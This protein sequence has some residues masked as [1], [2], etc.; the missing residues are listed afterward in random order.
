MLKAFLPICPVPGSKTALEPEQKFN[1]RS[2]QIFTP[3]EE[4]GGVHCSHPHYRRDEA[5]VRLRIQRGAID[6]DGSADGENA[7]ACR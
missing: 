6:R 7:T 4:T 1:Q 2:E 5:P 3:Q